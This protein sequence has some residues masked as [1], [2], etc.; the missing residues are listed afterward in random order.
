MLA[1]AIAAGRRILVLAAD[2]KMLDL[3]GSQGR[4]LPSNKPLTDAV[5]AGKLE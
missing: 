5:A 2:A 1:A 3:E 4:R